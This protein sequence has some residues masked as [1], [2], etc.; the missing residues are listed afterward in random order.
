M[1]KNDNTTAKV[2][3]FPKNLQENLSQLQT[4]AVEVGSLVRRVVTNMSQDSRN[5]VLN[6]FRRFT[7]MWS[8][9]LNEISGMLEN[10]STPQARQN[11]PVDNQTVFDQINRYIQQVTSSIRDFANGI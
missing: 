3:I 6:Q 8:K 7:D 5:T 11:G 10:V 9:Q 1:A 2:K 4:A